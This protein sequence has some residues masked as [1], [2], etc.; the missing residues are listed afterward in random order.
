M[1]DQRVVKKPGLTLRKLPLWGKNNG[2]LPD[3]EWPTK[4]MALD[5]HSKVSLDSIE[6]GSVRG[7]SNITSIKVNLTHDCL[8]SGV[9]KREST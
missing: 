4:E 6:F 2:S 8:S 9:F 7:C 5:M 1:G 3:F